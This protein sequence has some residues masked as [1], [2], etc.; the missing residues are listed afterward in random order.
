M[1]TRCFESGDNKPRPK[2]DD[3]PFVPS[4]TENVGQASRMRVSLL[5]LSELRPRAYMR[6]PSV[7]RAAS[8]L[9]RRLAP[10]VGIVTSRDQAVDLAT[11]AH[12]NHPASAA[13]MQSPLRRR[14]GLTQGLAAFDTSFAQ[15]SRDVGR[16]RIVQRRLSNR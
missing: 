9:K 4:I 1:S 5:P 10:S 12:K 16:H 7:R 13:G 3:A 15:A 11:G 14:S 2:L 6:A 8:A